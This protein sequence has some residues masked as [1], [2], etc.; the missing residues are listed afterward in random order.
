MATVT[1]SNRTIAITFADGVTFAVPHGISG[2]I[3][4]S[5]PNWHEYYATQTLGRVS[6]GWTVQKGWA[7]LLDSPAPGTLLGGGPAVTGSVTDMAARMALPHGPILAK[8]KKNALP[9]RA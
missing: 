5:L 1:D 9:K 4:P 2:G 7:M 3:G 8:S 6:D